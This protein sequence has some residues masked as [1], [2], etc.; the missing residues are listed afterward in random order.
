MPIKKTKFAGRRRKGPAR[1]RRVAGPTRSVSP[2]YQVATVVETLDPQSTFLD[3]VTINQSVYLQQFA[4]CNQMA[5][6]YE[7]FRIEEVAYTYSPLYNV[8]QENGTTAPSVPIMYSVMDRLGS[9]ASG[10]TVLND[11]VEMGARRRKFTKPITIKYRPNTM[12][13]T[14]VAQPGVSTQTLQINGADYGRWFPCVTKR[15][16]APNSNTPNTLSARVQTYNG[17]WVYFQQDVGSPTANLACSVSITVRVSFKNPMVNRLPTP[18]EQEVHVWTPQTGP[19][20]HRVLRQIG[21]DAPI[22]TS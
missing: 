3:N 16:G 21:A 5:N 12:V 2:Q 9:L 6:L 22:I 14:G 1:R 8:F 10:S 4:R 7:Q 19:R 20:E 15:F 17:H 11:L 18:E 13:T